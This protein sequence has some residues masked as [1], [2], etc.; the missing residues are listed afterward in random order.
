VV[1]EGNVVHHVKR[2]EILSRRG[3]VRGNISSMSGSLYST[4]VSVHPS[5]TQNGP[6][7]LEYRPKCSSSGAGISAVSRTGDFLV[8][9]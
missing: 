4:N 1:E 6:I 9:S 8:D 3:Y 2:E 5:V 7:Y